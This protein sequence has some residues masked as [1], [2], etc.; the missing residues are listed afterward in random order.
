M[1]RRR[2]TNNEVQ[3]SSADTQLAPL[4]LSLAEQHLQDPEGVRRFKEVLGQIIDD[5]EGRKGAG[6]TIQHIFAGITPSGKFV[7][8]SESDAV[9]EA[10]GVTVFVYDL[11]AEV[12]PEGIQP[13]KV[14][15]VDI[16]RGST[17]SIRLDTDDCPMPAPESDDDTMWRI[18]DAETITIKGAFRNPATVTYGHGM[19]GAE[20]MIPDFPHAR[21]EEVLPLTQY[22]SYL[23]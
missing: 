1:F 5:Y 17:H 11:G 14:A 7:E 9:A 23:E 13:A 2:N 8:F 20:Q 4:S 10:Q 12:P 3:S 16:T 15:E 21:P 19:E 22:A 6:E 18:G